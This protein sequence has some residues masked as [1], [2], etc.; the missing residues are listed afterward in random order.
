MSGTTLLS[1]FNQFEVLIAGS[2]PALK[3]SV[4]NNILYV[5]SVDPFQLFTY[6]SSANMGIIKVIKPLVFTGDEVGPVEQP[7]DTIDTIS[8]PCTWMGLCK[9]PW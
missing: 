5:E 4:V 6:S 9:Q 7:V 1:L 2:F 3:T 8:T